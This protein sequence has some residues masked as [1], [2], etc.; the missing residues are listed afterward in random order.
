MRKFQIAL[1]VITVAFSLAAWAADK[2]GDKDAAGSTLP[3]DQRQ[4]DDAKKGKHP[5]TSTM[6]RSVEDQKSPE[7]T[8]KH[9]PT[10][11][12]DKAMPPQKAP[13]K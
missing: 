6:D 4:A 11:A 12:M 3:A 2:P 1:P 10:S 7:G 13:E 9:P 5:P 8:K